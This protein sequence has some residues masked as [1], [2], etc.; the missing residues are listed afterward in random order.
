MVGTMASSRLSRALV[1]CLMVYSAE[2]TNAEDA[3]ESWV[4]RLDDV[5]LPEEASVLDLRISKG[6]GARGYESARI[7]VVSLNPSLEFRFPHR[8]GFSQKFLHRWT[9]EYDLGTKEHKCNTTAVFRDSRV[10]NDGECLLLCNLAQ[11]THKE[12]RCASY[13]Y[14]EKESLC[15][16]ADDSCGTLIKDSKATATYR[17][18]GH[19]YLHSALVRLSEGRHN[20]FRFQDGGQAVSA[21]VWLPT[22]GT[23]TSGIVWS[24]PCFSGRWVN[25]LYG[26]TWDT[27][28]QG[29]EMINAISQDPQIHFFS[30]L[31]DNF[32]DQDGRLTKAIYDRM[33]LETKSKFLLTALGN[34]DIW[35]SFFCSIC[36]VDVCFVVV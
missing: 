8:H 15:Q 34:H 11:G 25:C 12:P 2:L 26:E 20:I 30:I 1:A 24:D 7:S 16:L 5:S 31:G 17:N 4:A 28:H 21:S 3:F 23:G 6:V 19:R 33:S 32:Y 9:H 27:F 22:Q 13:T 36:Y 18:L 35:V 14:F 10:A 29:P